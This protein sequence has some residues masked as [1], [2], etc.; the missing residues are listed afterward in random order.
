MSAR[1]TLLAALQTTLSGLCSGRVYRS[2]KEQLPALPAIVIRPESEEGAGDLLG[3]QDATLLTAI[4]IYA[5]GDIPDQTADPILAAVES[6]LFA[7]PDL[8][9]GP[10][11][12]IKPGRRIEWDIENF[13]DGRATLHIEIIYR[14]P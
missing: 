3:R 4:D 2:R 5:S 8:G 1:E 12:Q 9:L 6:A 7:A 14:Q 10:D 11:V 13:D